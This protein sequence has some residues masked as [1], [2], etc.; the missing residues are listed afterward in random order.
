MMAVVVAR[1]LLINF[2]GAKTFNNTDKKFNEAGWRHDIHHNDIEHNDVY[3][4]DIHHNV[5]HL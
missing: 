5:I 1:H 4:D 2:F 3:H